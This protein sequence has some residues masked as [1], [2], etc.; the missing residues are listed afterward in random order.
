MPRML[1]DIFFIKIA[2][3]FSDVPAI[4]RFY[5]IKSTFDTFI[6]SSV[7]LYIQMFYFVS[8]LPKMHCFSFLFT[9]SNVL[10]QVTLLVEFKHACQANLLKQVFCCCCCCSNNNSSC[11]FLKSFKDNITR[12]MYIKGFISGHLNCFQIKFALFCLYPYEMITFRFM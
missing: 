11:C 10:T 6:N 4:S 5:E 8:M 2:H 3:T 1:S 7:S 12:L 9:F